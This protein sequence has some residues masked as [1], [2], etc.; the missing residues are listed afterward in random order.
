[1]TT[2]VVTLPG[3]FTTPLTEQ[4]RATLMKGLRPADPSRTDF[5]PAAELD[6]L[7]VDTENS[8]F[9]VRLEVEAGN[10][11]EAELNA[12]E[13]ASSALLDAGR[14][15]RTAPMGEAAITGIEAE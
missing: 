13:I 3:T 15:E 9:T 14:T 4:E 10:S 12:R 11:T 1:M 6:V 2:F 7:T 5:E 8:T